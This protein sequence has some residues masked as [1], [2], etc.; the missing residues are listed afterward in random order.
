MYFTTLKGSIK[1]IDRALFKVLTVQSRL[2]GTQ[3]LI[4]PSDLRSVVADAMGL[5]HQPETIEVHYRNLRDAGHISRARKAKGAVSA[6]IPDAVALMIALLGSQMVK[7]SAKAFA[8]YSALSPNPGSLSIRRPREAYY[9]KRKQGF[10]RRIFK[11]AGWMEAEDAFGF[12]AVATS[13]PFAP[14]LV[15][16]LELLA[17]ETFFTRAT[18]CSTSN[19]PIGWWLGQRDNA[20]AKMEQLLADRRYIT[21]RLFYP[22]QAASIHFG[23]RRWRTVSLGYGAFPVCNPRS[24]ADLDNLNARKMISMRLVDL[25][26][27]ESIATRFRG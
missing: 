8:D 2:E 16:I 12:E 22:M 14:A 21:V 19:S 17:A 9:L 10:D 1:C 5:S 26:V 18:T 6:G 3:M 27:L 13:L 11:Q 7:E 24:I 15:K 4:S 23:L 25:A 20:G